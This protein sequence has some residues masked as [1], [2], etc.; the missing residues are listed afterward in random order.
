MDTHNICFCEKIRKLWKLFFLFF[1]FFRKCFIW[2]RV[3]T[4]LTLIKF[5]I[6]FFTTKW[7]SLSLVFK[8]IVL[9]P[10]LLIRLFL[11]L[12]SIDIFLIFPWKRMLWVLNRSASERHFYEYPQH[13]FSWRNKKILSGYPLLPRPMR[14][15]FQQDLKPEPP[16]RKHAYIILIS[17]NPTFI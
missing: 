12:K 5:S 9:T 4:C 8:Q 17:L 16:S 1:S 10:H 13:M 3:R 11:R 15:N 14:I 2:H 7:L 6:H